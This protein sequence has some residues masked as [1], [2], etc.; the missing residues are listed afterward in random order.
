VHIDLT[1]YYR[2]ETVSIMYSD[3]DASDITSSTL[4]ILIKLLRTEMPRPIAALL[5]LILVH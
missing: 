3:S 2:N 4:L 5:S 1:S